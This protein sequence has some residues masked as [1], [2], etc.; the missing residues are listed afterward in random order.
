MPHAFFILCLAGIDSPQSVT[1][2]RPAGALTAAAL[3]LLVLI[4]I[5]TILLILMG[6]S[7]P[8]ALGV[9]GGAGVVAVKLRRD[10]T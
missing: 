2:D 10:L 1:P 7:P 6:S 8:I 4:L 3:W 5:A 9:M